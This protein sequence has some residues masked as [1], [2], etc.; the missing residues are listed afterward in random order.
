MESHAEARV[1]NNLY[2]YCFF[3]G[4]SSLSP[5]K[6]IDNANDTTVLCYENLCALVSPVPID[7]YN[8]EALEHRLVDL[9]WLTPRVKRHEEIIRYAQRVHPVIPVRFGTIY[10]SDERILAVLREGYD[11]FCSYLDFISGKEEWGVKAYAK[12]Y[13]GRRA[14]EATSELIDEL[15]ERISS[16]GSG[17]QVYL[18]KKKRE[19][20]IHQQ[21]VDFLNNL[22]NKIHQ[23]ILSWSVEGRKNKVLSRRATGKDGDMI[24]NAAFLLDTKDVEDFKE[25]IDTLAAEYSA[26]NLFFEISGP[27]PCY[28]F[29]P[30]FNF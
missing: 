28:S 25:R 15:D 14:I 10:A 6:G 21:S 13:A 26:D 7:E 9:E 3:K 4:S 11:R 30:D 5:R 20:I 22:S 8:E 2:L 18:L 23:Q 16:A 19:N 12:E 17:G 29:C 24:L 1:G 27:W